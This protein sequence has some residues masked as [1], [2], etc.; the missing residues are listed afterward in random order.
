[1]TLTTLLV[2]ALGLLGAVAAVWLADEMSAVLDSADR[3]QP[4][5]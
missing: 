3:D 5:D 1:M 2:V 4:P